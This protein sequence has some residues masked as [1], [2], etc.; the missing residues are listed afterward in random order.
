MEPAAQQIIC[1]EIDPS[2]METT[3]GVVYVCV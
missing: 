1:K 3:E 2:D